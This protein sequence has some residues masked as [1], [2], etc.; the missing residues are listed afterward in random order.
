M[1]IIESDQYRSRGQAAKEMLERNGHLLESGQKELLGITVRRAE[2]HRR[3]ED[4]VI[5]KKI[6]VAND[7]SEK[8]VG[9]FVTLDDNKIHITEEIMDDP[10][11]AKKVA[12]HEDGHVEHNNAGIRKIDFKEN[13]EEEAYK[14]IKEYLAGYGFD[15][16]QVNFI[17]GF[18]EAKTARKFGK[19]EKCAYNLKEVPAVER[20]EEL[21]M[22]ELG[23]S[24]IDAFTQNNIALVY[25]LVESAVMVLSVKRRLSLAA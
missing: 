23:Q 13:L 12:Q 16:D 19:N 10:D 20:L 14:T 6:A 9:G 2:V 11:L 17:E 15:L 7:N 5:G 18:N 4:T 24:V 8:N 3:L 22:K 21:C 1:N 25:E